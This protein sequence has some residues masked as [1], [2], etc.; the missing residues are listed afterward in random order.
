MICKKLIQISNKLHL[1]GLY[2]ESITIK[3]ILKYNENISKTV[4]EI[5]KFIGEF[6]EI[7][8][9]NWIKKYYLKWKM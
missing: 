4:E 1:K 8:I 6:N 7:L 2:K 9:K 5:N 3:K